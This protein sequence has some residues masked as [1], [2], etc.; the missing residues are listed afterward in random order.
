MRLCLFQTS[1]AYEEGKIAFLFEIP[2]VLCPFSVNLISHTYRSNLTI[3]KFP[4]IPRTRVYFLKIPK[5]YLRSRDLLLFCDD[6]KLS[7]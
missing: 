7:V 3:F 5:Q 4:N 1:L 6:L 2:T